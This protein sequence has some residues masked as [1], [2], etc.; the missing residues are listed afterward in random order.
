MLLLWPC[1]EVKLSTGSETQVSGPGYEKGPQPVSRDRCLRL[2][3]VTLVETS[4]GL[5]ARCQT[6]QNVSVGPIRAPELLTSC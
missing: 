1:R 2:E 4:P 5:V 6:R 3:W